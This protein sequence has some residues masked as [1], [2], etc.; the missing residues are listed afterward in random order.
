MN[1]LDKIVDTIL[2]KDAKYGA[3]RPIIEKEIL[4]YDIIRE[5]NKA[6]FLKNLTFIGGTCLRKC[7]DSQRLSED[8]DFSANPDFK[9]QDMNQI[10]SL[11]QD[12]FKKKYDFN[13][14]IEPPQKDIIDTYTWKIKIITHP[15]QSHLPIQKINIDICLL[16]SY[17]RNPVMLKDQYGIETGAFGIILYAE[18]LKEILTDKIIAIALRSNRVKNRDLWDIVWLHSKNIKPSNDLLEKKLADRK[19]ELTDFKHRYL[20][21]I[22]ELKDKQEP[23]ISEMRRFLTPNSFDDDF[24]NPIWWQ[25]LMVLLSDYAQ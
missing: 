17:E 2:E 22:A 1:L 12:S 9:E 14:S 6:G 21:R 10:T 15:Q 7:Y 8:I 20:Q 13:A 16:P 25:H 19:I 5:M 4:H 18:T 23:F 3:M 11:I 24:I